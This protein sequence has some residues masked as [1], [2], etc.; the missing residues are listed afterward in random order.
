MT[1]TPPAATTHYLSITVASNPGPCYTSI[2]SHVS[3]FT[4]SSHSPSC[5]YMIFMTLF[6]SLHDSHDSSH[7]YM[8]LKDFLTF[9]YHKNVQNISLVSLTIIFPTGA[10]TLA[11]PFFLPILLLPHSLSMSFKNIQSINHRI[12]ELT[13]CLIN[14]RPP[15]WSLYPLNTNTTR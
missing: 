12:A 3:H 9:R 14:I 2:Y 7:L 6:I 1:T 8:V 5:L 11:N 13:F 15:S 10:S 4:I